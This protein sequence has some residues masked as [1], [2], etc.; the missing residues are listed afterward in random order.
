MGIVLL[1]VGIVSGG[2]FFL[3]QCWNC[4]LLVG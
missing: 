1:L 4:S 2:G 3:L